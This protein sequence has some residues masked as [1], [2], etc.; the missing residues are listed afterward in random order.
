[1]YIY[2]KELD[3]MRPSIGIRYRWSL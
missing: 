3:Q 1:M 2:K